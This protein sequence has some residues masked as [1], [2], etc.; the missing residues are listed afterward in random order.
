MNIRIHLVILFTAITT[1]SDIA[2]SRSRFELPGVVKQ[3][4]EAG[5]GELVLGT[6]ND[7]R[8]IRIDCSPQY[9]LTPNWKYID[10]RRKP[11]KPKGVICIVD[12]ARGTLIFKIPFNWNK[13]ADKGLKENLA[14]YK[15]KKILSVEYPLHNFKC[16]L[17]IESKVV[18]T[19]ESEYQ[20]IY[21]VTVDKKS[22][23]KFGALYLPSPLLRS[24]SDADCEIIK[25][26]IDVS[27]KE[28][29]TY[30]S[31]FELSWRRK[32]RNK[33]SKRVVVKGGRRPSVFY[34]EP[35]GTSRYKF[36]SDYPPA[37]LK[38]QADC[39]VRRKNQPSLNLVGRIAE[40]ITTRMQGP[41]VAYS[42]IPSR[43]TSGLGA[44]E[45]IGMIRDGIDLMNRAG[46]INGI[47]GK[48]ILDGIAKIEQFIGDKEK[49][50]RAVV[51]LRRLIESSKESLCSIE[52]KSFLTIHLDLLKAG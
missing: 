39:S 32:P 20:Y 50:S 2:W 43:E 34:V 9:T 36:S 26:K 8:Y 48:K 13:V 16:M 42:L 6:S 45:R 51:R 28:P 33:P 23:R 19:P 41:F 1:I 3:L 11:G 30:Y 46:W 27:I 40:Y 49:L 38:V 7:G 44:G 29:Y 10:V 37:I 31:T 15:K 4:K 17:Y 52:C 22:K 14:K 12:K 35:G 21:T 25:P 47:M 18:R 24:C 5:L